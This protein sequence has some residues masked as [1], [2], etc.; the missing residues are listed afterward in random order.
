LW[1]SDPTFGIS[2][3]LGF[4]LL[5]TILCILYENYVGNLSV[6]TIHFFLFKLA[7]NVPTITNFPATW[8]EFVYYIIYAYVWRSSRELF[9]WMETSSLR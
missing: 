9:K 5:H 8:I 1:S 2:K 7:E 4:F 6:F 3:S